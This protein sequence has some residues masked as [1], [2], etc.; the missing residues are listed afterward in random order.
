LLNLITDLRMPLAFSHPPSVL[1]VPYK[2]ESSN[3]LPRQERLYG[4][5]WPVQKPSTELLSLEVGSSDLPVNLFEEQYLMAAPAYMAKIH[6]MVALLGFQ[7]QMVHEIIL[8]IA[9]CLHEQQKAF[10]VSRSGEGELL[11]YTQAHEAIRNLLIDAEGDVEFLYI[12][13]RNRQNSYH[14]LYFREEGFNLSE[15]A[16][17]L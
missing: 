16:D 14:Q 13:Q 8:P 5:F 9:Q 1:L 2:R 6:E 15:L 11:L 12:D 10:T 4:S 17:L 7:T 3:Y